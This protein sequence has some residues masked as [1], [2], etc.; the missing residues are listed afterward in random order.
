MMSNEAEDKKFEAW[1]D[2]QCQ[3]S[4]ER[5]RVAGDAIKRPPNWGLG[6]KSWARLGWMGR[7]LEEST[8]P[9]P[10]PL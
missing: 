7:A 4:W 8:R 9:K 2:D 1:W 3:A 10:S 5:T 6:H